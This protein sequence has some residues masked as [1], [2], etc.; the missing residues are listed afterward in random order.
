MHYALE[1]FALKSI[2]KRCKSRLNHIAQWIGERIES[3]QEPNA[4]SN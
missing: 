4:V 1:W 3:Q 2:D